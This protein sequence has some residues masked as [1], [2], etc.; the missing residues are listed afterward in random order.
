[1]EAG[2]ARIIMNADDLG[3]SPETNR[4]IAECAE[5]GAVTSFSLMANLPGFEDARARLRAGLP[6]SLGVHLNFTLGEP[7][8]RGADTRPLMGS[9]GR[10]PG[11][12]AM[13]LRLAAGGGRSLGESLERE[14][15]AQIE[16]V[17]G[18]GPVWHLDVHHHLHGFPALLEV[19]V[20]LAGEFRIPAL[21]NPREGVFLAPG[22]GRLPWKALLLRFLARKAPARIAAAGLRRPDVLY[23]TVLSQSRDLGRTLRAL[24]E[25]AGP[26]V[27]EIALHPGYAAPSLRASDPFQGRRE[28]TLRVLRGEETRKALAG[29]RVRLISFRDLAERGEAG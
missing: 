24:L 8:L 4:G 28:E 26:G 15:R 16:R 18:A 21:R 12:G 6:G 3:M 5:A 22:G 23:A 27:S 17:L 11:L 2:A 9:G 14:A 1:M 7:L 20:R 13:V 19:L 25:G 10:F 29:A